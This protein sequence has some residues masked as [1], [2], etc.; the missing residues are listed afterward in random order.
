MS[1]S[2][3][4]GLS[5]WLLRA[6]SYL[7]PVFSFK[8]SVSFELRLCLLDGQPTV[9]FPSLPEEVR[10]WTPA[11]FSP[12]FLSPFAVTSPSICNTYFHA[13]LSFKASSP[14]MTF[15]PSFFY[16]RVLDLVVS[17]DVITTS[18]SCPVHCLL[19]S[20]SPLV[21]TLQR[22]CDSIAT[23]LWFPTTFF[24]TQDFYFLL[25]PP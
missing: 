15:P 2:P 12:R 11:C 1:Q 4:A 21:L 23:S 13:V 6:T 14:S 24:T 18:I 3:R 5:S 7:T 9:T 10:P 8:M 22:F 19:F 16:G 20:Q 17:N 25:F